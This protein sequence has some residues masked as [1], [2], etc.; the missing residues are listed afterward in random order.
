MSIQAENSQ[1]VPIQNANV[2]VTQGDVF[3]LGKTITSPSTV[4]GGD[5][6]GYKAG[7]ETG[8]A[9]TSSIAQLAIPNPTLPQAAQIFLSPCL[10]VSPPSGNTSIERIPVLRTAQIQNIAAQRLKIPNVLL[11]NGSQA[12]K[13]P[14][15]QIYL[16][17]HV[18]LPT[19]IPVVRTVQLLKNATIPSTVAPN[20][21]PSQEI[22]T[23]SSQD[24]QTSR[25]Q[26]P[27]TL[28]VQPTLEHALQQDP[29]N[30][31]KCN[32]AQ[33]APAPVI[34]SYQT[35]VP[36]IKEVTQ[37]ITGGTVTATSI[38]NSQISHVSQIGVASA[39]AAL[40]IKDGG[41]CY[42]VLKSPRL[43]SNA[44]IATSVNEQMF[45]ASLARNNFLRSPKHYMRDIHKFLDKKYPNDAVIP[46][47]IIN[48]LIDTEDVFIRYKNQYI[49]KGKSRAA[50]V[51]QIYCARLTR[52]ARIANN[53]GNLT[54]ETSKA[55]MTSHSSRKG[56]KPKNSTAVMSSE[57]TLKFY[58]ESHLWTKRP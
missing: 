7:L 56:E 13:T 4:L 45:E 36:P 20:I 8:R 19:H 9:L 22:F 38:R 21:L 12:P 42:S 37:V 55:N 39:G 25:Q 31:S 40:A 35:V 57:V 18:I 28:P 17:S 52:L 54:S 43:Q 3:R 24:L 58:L 49:A 14:G 15:S 34:R 33:V 16:P 11:P 53:S 50:I 10:Q 46:S 44:K 5:S 1:V 27:S 47:A 51:R 26:M 23:R 29:N 30:R 2:N 48:V 32:V 41:N 6:N